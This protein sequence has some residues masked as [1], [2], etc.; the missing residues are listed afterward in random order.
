[1]SL[2]TEPQPTI[3]LFKR[4]N[5]GRAHV[6]L[7]LYSNPNG[8]TMSQLFDITGARGY[9]QEVVRRGASEGLIERVQNGSP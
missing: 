3:N 5:M 9:T 7:V 6:L 8:L 2:T 1:M 4:G